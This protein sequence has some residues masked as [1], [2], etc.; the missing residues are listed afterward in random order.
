MRDSHLRYGP[1]RIDDTKI[2]K[3]ALMLTC[4]VL[5]RDADTTASTGMAQGERK[6]C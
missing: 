4:H 2:H 1:S 3:H 6:G 5:R